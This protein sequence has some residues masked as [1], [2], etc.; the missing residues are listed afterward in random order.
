MTSKIGR[1]IRFFTGHV[2]MIAVALI[3]SSEAFA[4]GKISAKVVDSKTGEALVR[5]T[6][7]ILQTKQGAYTKDNGVATIINIQPREDYTVIAKFVGYQESRVLKVKVQS[8]ITT[9]LTFRLTREGSMDTVVVRADRQMVEKSRTEQ[10]RKF[11]QS[12][13]QNTPGRQRLD[14]IIKLTPGVYTD[15]ANGGLSINGGRGYTNSVRLNGVEMQDVVDGRTSTIQNSLSKFAVSELDIKTSGSD[16]SSGSTLGGTINTTTRSGGDNFT[17]QAH[18]RQEIPALFGTGASGFK[19]MPE[20]SRILEFALGGPTPLEALSYFVTLK[21]WQRDFFNYFTEPVYSNEGLGVIDPAGNNLGQIPNRQFYSRSATGNLTYNLAGFRLLGSA[22]YASESRRFGSAGSLFMDQEMIPGQN[23]LNSIYSLNIQGPISD[24]IVQLNGSFSTFRRDIGRVVPGQ[25]YNLFNPFDIYLPED[26]YTYDEANRT[27]IA[28]PDGII[29]LYTPVSRQIPSPSN[30]ANTKTAVG[31]NP[32]TGKVEGP[33]IVLSSANAYGLPGYYVVG[34][35]GGGGFQTDTRNQIQVDGSY[36]QQWGAHFLTAGFESK[37]YDISRNSND[38]PWDANPFKDS[39]NVDP[40][41]GGVYLAD[42]MEFSDITFN[43]SLRFDIYNPGGM[44]L[45]DLYNPVIQDSGRKSARMEA[46]PMQSQLSPRLGITY[47]VTEQTTFNFNYNWYF[48]PPLFNTVLSNLGGDVSKVLQRGNQTLGNGG[49]SAERAK[50]IVVGFNTQL[51]EHFMFLLQGVYKD[52]RNQAGLQR[53][54]SDFLPVGYT[55]YSDDQYGNYRAMQFT[56][57]KRMADNWGAR[58]NYTLSKSRATSSSAT[59]NYQRLISNDPSSEEQVLPLAPFS[60][61]YDK[62]HIIQLILNTS[63]GRGEGPELFG[64]RILQHFSMNTT[65]SYESGI[66][67]TKLDLRGQQVGEFN[68]ERHPDYFQTDA[69]ITRSIPFGDLFG[70]SMNSMF[71]DV[72]LEVTNLFNITRPIYVFATTG[73]GDDDGTSGNYVYT[74]DFDYDPTS[75]VV[76]QFDAFGR[77]YYNRR[78]DLNSDNTVTKDEQLK[79]Y[80]QLRQDRLDR[81][82]RYQAPRRVFLNLSFRF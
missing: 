35:N 76:S 6:V 4:Q 5:A 36:R 16:A 18:Y 61:A 30:P 34:G 41:I 65:S 1:H 47:A 79:A 63:W 67:F 27:I 26:K 69:T 42:K 78:W 21:G 81:R 29:D 12:E 38:L 50:E 82:T 33:P 2:L 74:S 68:A 24:A 59:E 22:T 3:V 31:T 75:T 9:D 56:A 55:I 70:E 51:S 17:F 32:F 44:Q 49:L 28:E 11:S 60:T 48:K 53:I 10:G 7:Q 39:F 80:N 20:G 25:S 72:E 15:N 66:P 57:E 14:E 46:T 8:D 13:V 45:V 64:T 77:P 37:I 62:P 71:L 58:L 43:P 54:S 52:F 73:V 40:F 19:Q 23:E